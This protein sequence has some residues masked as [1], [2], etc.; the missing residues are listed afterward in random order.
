MLSLLLKIQSLCP[1]AFSNLNNCL[2]C[3]NK[4]INAQD[5]PKCSRYFLKHVAKQ[6]SNPYYIP[7]PEYEARRIS[8]EA[9]ADMPSPDEKNSPD[10]RVGERTLEVVILAGGMGS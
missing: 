10:P 2:G 6:I 3:V 1:F 7:K 4:Q 8:G 5:T 9:G